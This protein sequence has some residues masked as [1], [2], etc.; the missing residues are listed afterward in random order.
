MSTRALE[1]KSQQKSGRAIALPAPPPP[2]SL[3]YNPSLYI[4]RK[5][6]RSLLHPNTAQ[7]FFFPLQSYSKKNL[8]KD[9]PKIVRKYKRNVLMPSLGTL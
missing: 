9:V 5:K 7:R 6:K 8:R 3:K 4:S 2:R 1:N